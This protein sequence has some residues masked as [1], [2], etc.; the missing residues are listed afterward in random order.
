M[1]FDCTSD[2]FAIEELNHIAQ[3]PKFGSD[4]FGKEE[5]LH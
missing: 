3:A 5:D 1:E 2:R 4:N